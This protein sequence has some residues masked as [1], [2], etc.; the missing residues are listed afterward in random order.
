MPTAMGVVSMSKTATASACNHPKV[1]SYIMPGQCFSGARLADAIRLRM[2][3]PKLPSSYNA[4]Y[5]PLPP[6]EWTTLL[7]SEDN[8]A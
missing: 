1:N 3:A 4:S 5:F 6:R 8:L 7:S 2:T